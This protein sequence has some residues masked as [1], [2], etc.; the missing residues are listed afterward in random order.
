MI[1]S[2][3][4]LIIFSTF[5]SAAQQI[6]LVVSKDFNTSS[7]K[8]ECFEGAD[9][10]CESF[11]VNIG[12]KGL[13]WGLGEIQLKKNAGDAIKYE[14]DKKAPI[15]VFKLSSVFAYSKSNNFNMPYLHA[16]KKLICVDDSNSKKY[17]KIIPMPKKKPQSF[18][19]MK[20][21]DLQYELGIVVEH[22]QNAIAGRGSCIFIHVQKAESAG[23]AGC[24]SMKLDHL[25]KIVSWL[26]E[27]KN[28]ILIQIPESSSAEV[29]ELYPELKN[30]TL[31]KNQ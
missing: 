1:K 19:Y 22:N 11:D 4:I 2:F 24:T 5:L 16:S 30:S 8:M 31:L 3:L 18:E 14:G 27:K 17:N 13:G 23:T 15:G 25:K 28:P 29:L 20:R 7:A 12:Q 21:D 10:I 6:I 9:I 26:D